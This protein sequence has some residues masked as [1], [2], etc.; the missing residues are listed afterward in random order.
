MDTEEHTIETAGER[1]QTCGTPLTEQEL[2]EA[3][4]G[5]GPVLCT[6]HASEENA[7]D[8]P[9]QSDALEPEE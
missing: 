9:E 6:V 1:C 8:D 4:L 7:V 5:G 2:R 3:L